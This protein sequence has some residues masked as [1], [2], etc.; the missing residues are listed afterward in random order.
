MI[1]KVNCIHNDQGAW[2]KHKEVKRSLWGLG[3]RICPLHGELT[4]CQHQE[5]K[6]IKADYVGRS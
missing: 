3:A 4:T 2:C 5:V 6:S 1:I